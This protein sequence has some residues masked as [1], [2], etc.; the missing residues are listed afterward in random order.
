MCWQPL[1]VAATASYLT[2]RKWDQEAHKKISDPG[3]G[4]NIHCHRAFHAK[5]TK[6]PTENVLLSGCKA[7]KRDSQKCGC[8]WKIRP[9]RVDYRNEV[10]WAFRYLKGGVVPRHAGGCLPSAAKVMDVEKSR[11]QPLQPE[12]IQGSSALAVSSQA[13]QIRDFLIKHHIKWKYDS[14]SL[15]NLRLRV[16]AYTRK[17]E[18]SDVTPHISDRWKTDTDP[19]LNKI[20]PSGQEDPSEEANDRYVCD[21]QTDDNSAPSKAEAIDNVESIDTLHYDEYTYQSQPIIDGMPTSSNRIFNFLLNKSKT[22][23]AVT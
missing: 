19:E 23:A 16:L 15:R 18:M 17:M 8:E 10:F 6:V 4:F 9:F 5:T 3:N 1:N 11:R 14:K 22:L 20:Y 21:Q 2:V 7:R 12:L 13:G